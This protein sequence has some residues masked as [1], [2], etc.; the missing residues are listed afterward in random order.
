MVSSKLLLNEENNY[1]YKPTPCDICK[2]TKGKMSGR[3][4]VGNEFNPNYDIDSDWIDCLIFMR[5]N[6]TE[7]EHRKRINE[8][9]LKYEKENNTD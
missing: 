5:T 4:C 3:M 7:E 2:D 9:R 8:Q 1:G 6:E